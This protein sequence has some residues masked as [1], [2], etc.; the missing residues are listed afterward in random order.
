MW[1][2]EPAQN[3]GMAKEDGG[4]RVKVRPQQDHAAGPTA[5]AVSMKRSV[6]RMGPRRTAQTLL[7]LNQAEGFDCMSCAWP[8]PE[9]GH[10]HTAE[11]C[12][13]GAKAVAE[14][15]TTV[16]ATPEFFARHSI[17][18]L[19]AHSEHWLGQ[20][21]RI[22]APMVKRPGDSHYRPI[23]WDA[24]FDLI[25][26]E[27]RTLDSPDEA[28]FYTS[29]RTS[30]EAAFAYQLF[31][32]AYGTNNLPDC[33]NM[34]HEST[35]LALAESIG[36]GKASVTL[37]D[38]HAASL[39]VLAGQNPGTNHPR[40]LSALEEAK[41]RGA[42]I[43]AIN[44]LKEAGLVG[45]KNPQRPRGWVGSGVH[46]A[47]LHL[48]VRIN[49]D[50]A[51]FQAFGALL[52]EWDALDHDF[53]ARHTNG[54]PSGGNT[55]GSWTGPR[56]SAPPDSPGPRSSRRR[57][58]CGI[59]TPPSSAG[60]WASPSTTTPWPPSRRSPTSRSRRAT[61]GSRE[62]G[63]CRSGATPT[64]RVTGPWA[65]G[66]GRRTTSSTRCRR[67][68]ASIRRASTGSTRSTPSAPCGTARRRSSSRLGGNF[69]QAAPDTA[70]TA[71]RSAP[72]PAHGADLDQDQPLPPGLRRYGVD[73]ADVAAGPRRTS[74]PAANR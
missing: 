17:A 21:G 50:L 57:P 24:A 7:R 68:S 65:S 6:E 47:D 23:G 13:N 9:V 28:I 62:P 42:T 33:S 15:A 18:E 19:D 41:R 35:S 38:V 44:P 43:I 45:F 56:S 71:E 34:C 36:I 16:R 30:N 55:C 66:S 53:I 51:L 8:D 49:G 58:C 3:G 31:V 10:R 60:P 69:V 54:F 37:E 14:E 72:G 12:E 27:L 1:V 29:G 74:R 39:I 4:D 20:Q 67:S 25:A 63:C 2:G 52:V 5:V 64:S 40:M 11:F 73:P 61:S 32:R 48:P 22:T 59:P 46:L 26:A 70:V